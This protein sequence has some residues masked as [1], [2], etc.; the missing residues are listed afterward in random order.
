MNCMFLLKPSIE[1]LFETNWQ[2]L[3]K[4]SYDSFLK[5]K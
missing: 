5:N 1:N 4:E 2:S 3:V